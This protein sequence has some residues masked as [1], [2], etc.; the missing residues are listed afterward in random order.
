MEERIRGITFEIPNEYG[1]WLYNILRPIDCTKYNWFIGPGEG[2]ISVENDL[3]PLFPTDLDSVEGVALLEFIGTKEVQYI[4]HADLKAY[5][6]GT[7]TNLNTYEDYLSSDCELVLLIVDCTYTTI[8]C[9]DSDNLHKLYAN[10]EALNV[11]SLI[12]IT[13]GNDHRTGLGVW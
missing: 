9:K 4:I 8:Y 2:Y 1:K 6:S 10:A 12:Y 5:S 11:S 7:I 13:D 3:V